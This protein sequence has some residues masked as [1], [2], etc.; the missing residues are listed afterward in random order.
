MLPSF[1]AGLPARPDS[2]DGAMAV[3]L[4]HFNAV[5]L[6]KIIHFAPW[7]E[8]LIKIRRRDVIITIDGIMIFFVIPF[9]LMEVC[10]R[11]AAWAKA[12]LY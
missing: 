10:P 5:K 2:S 9:F 7:E 11:V 3:Q 1:L 12:I 8:P 6:G 4:Q